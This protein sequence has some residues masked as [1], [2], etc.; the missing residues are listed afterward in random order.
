M[1]DPVTIRFAH[2]L[3]WKLLRLQKR[4]LYEVIL[5][6][7]NNGDPKPNIC[8]GCFTSLTLSRTI[9]KSNWE[10]SPSDRVPGKQAAAMLLGITQSSKRICRCKEGLTLENRRLHRKRYTSN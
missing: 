4:S 5:Q 3:E 7:K 1:A 6:L 8:K 2:G 10:E 9:E